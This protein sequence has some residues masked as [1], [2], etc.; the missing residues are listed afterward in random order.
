MTSRLTNNRYSLL[1][2]FMLL[3]LIF[4]FIT[5]TAF[6]L[7]SL[8]SAELTFPAV[9]RIYLQGF[10]FD[11]GVAVLFAVPYALYLL[12]LPQRWNN[13][14]VNRV[15][16][17]AG[18]MLLMLIIL[19]S[20]FAEFAFWDEFESRFNFI[21]VDYLIYT[22]EVINN[23]NES[24][25]MPVLI[26]CMLLAVLLITY[27]FRRRRIFTT[28]FVSNTSF[29]KRLVMSLSLF[30]VAAFY[31]AFVKNSW[32]ET[33]RNRYQNELSKAGIYSFFAAYRNNELSYAQFYKMMNNEEAFKVLRQNLSGDSVVFNP[34]TPYIRRT[35]HHE[36]LQ[37]K[38]NVIMIT[39]ES[40]SADFMKT[41]GNTQNLTPFLDSLASHSILF[42]DMYATGNRT[43]RGMEA[44][45]LC[46]PPTPGSSIVRRLDNNNLF[47]VGTVFK[48]KSYQPTFIYGGDG[49]FDN[50]NQY[51]SGNGYNIMDRGRNILPGDDLQSKRQIIPD[52]LVSFENAWG[53][54][55]ED[56]YD[57]VI[58]DADKHHAAGKLFYDFVMTTS[59]H[60][61]YT[62][63]AGK[64]DIPSGSGREGAVKYTDYAIRQ[65]FKKIANKPWFE[66]TV[67]ILVAD[68]C[69]NSAGKNAIDLSKY[70]IPCMIVNLKN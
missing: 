6:L 31:I 19:F 28:S 67:I 34:N 60:K 40:F 68:H 27:F 3:I 35:L 22:Y 69:A 58:R 56:L 46:I 17:Y 70:H 14:K 29:V 11:M 10:V 66:N 41:F 54:S 59:N 38:P 63:P 5:R 53:I 57:A 2:A 13:S 55:D 42:T 50:M 32:A 25:P 15:V 4:S 45:S 36:P 51:F 52:S 21:A 12:V 18:F 16:T 65:F 7:L 39:I 62:Y 37:V 24:Y 8:S 9:L 23:I 49:Y 44:L 48:S 61:P 47:T 33:S 64:I 1:F 30:L 20:F 26:S 43:V